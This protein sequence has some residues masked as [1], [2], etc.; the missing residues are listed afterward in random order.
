M[1]EIS[2]KV[3]KFKKVRLITKKENLLMELNMRRIVVQVRKKGQI[4]L[5]I[6]IRKAFDIS[7]GSKLEL[8]PTQESILIKPVRK[9]KV[10]ESSG[11]LGEGGE[12]EL[13]LAILDP[14][15]LSHYFRRRYKG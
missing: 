8:I 13:E 15:L 14:E 1:L 9:T 4:T 7:E 10:A 2:I 11:A 6:K 3:G 12:D 5:P